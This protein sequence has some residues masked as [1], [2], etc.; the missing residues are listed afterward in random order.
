MLI[1]ERYEPDAELEDLIERTIGAAIEVHRRLGAGMLE[2][3]YENALCVELEHR[4]I[5][6]QRQVPFRLQYRNQPIGELRVDLLIGSRLIVELKAVDQLHGLHTTQVVSY[7]KATGLHVALLINF[8][9]TV[10]RDGIKRI[11]AS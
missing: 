7:L 9:V 8:N 5:P 6:F 2:M 11:I 4:S 3:N 1:K 10:L